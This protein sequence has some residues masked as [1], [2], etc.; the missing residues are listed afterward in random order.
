MLP[1]LLRLSIRI[2]D[3]GVA[4]SRGE[5]NTHPDDILYSSDAAAASVKKKWGMLQPYVLR[6]WPSSDS[7]DPHPGDGWDA[8]K[9]DQ[10]TDVAYRFNL[11]DWKKVIQHA[12]RTTPEAQAD[13]RGLFEERYQ[14]ERSEVFVGVLREMFQKQRLAEGVQPPAGACHY[15]TP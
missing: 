6:G 10:L 9:H 15:S 3:F 7:R 13:K 11:H 2:V 4:W 5:K 8:K 14:F 1:E 12:G